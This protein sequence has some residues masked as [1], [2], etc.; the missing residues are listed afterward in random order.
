MRAFGGVDEPPSSPSSFRQ[1]VL[2]TWD[3]GWRRVGGLYVGDLGRIRILEG[4]PV[5][6]SK[7]QDRGEERSKIASWPPS[8]LLESKNRQCID[9]I[10]SSTLPLIN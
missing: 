3:V 10:T 5:P 2:L 4:V 1:V 7:K 8:S 6:L 9:N